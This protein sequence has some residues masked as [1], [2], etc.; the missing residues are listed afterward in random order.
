[1]AL[2]LNGSQKISKPWNS[3]FFLADELHRLNS[4]FEQQQERGRERENRKTERKGGEGEY[5]R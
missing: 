3:N 1:M 2:G 5:R 4:S